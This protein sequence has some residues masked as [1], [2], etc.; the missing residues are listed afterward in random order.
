MATIQVFTVLAAAFIYLI[1][2]YTIR[3][4]YYEVLSSCLVYSRKV[5]SISFRATNAI[6]HVER[7]TEA[8]VI[9]SQ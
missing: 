5:R 3:Y 1:F 4:H 2:H 6:Y 9:K 8:N 7:D